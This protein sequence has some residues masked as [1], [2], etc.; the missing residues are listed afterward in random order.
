MKEPTCGTLATLAALALLAGGAN[1]VQACRICFPLPKKSIAD[2]LIE[3]ESVLLA[4]EDP[5]RPFHFRPTRLLKGAQPG[6]PLELFLDSGT[7][8]I[9]KAHP[10]RSILLVKSGKW[11]RLAMVD[12][13][14]RP[15]L[16]DILRSAP[17]W[18]DATRLD[19]FAKLF[20]HEHAVIRELA[21]LEVARAPYA[22]LRKIGRNVPRAKLRSALNDPRYMEWWALDILL[23]A[24]SEDARDKQ[25]IVDTVRSLARFDRPLHLGAWAT[26]YIEIEGEKAIQFFESQYFRRSRRVEELRE[27][28]LA[29]SVHGKL[30]RRDRI[31]A[32][33][34]VL[35]DRHPAL[36]SAVLDDLIAWKRTEMV[37]YMKA[38]GTKQARA[39]MPD[40]RFKLQRFL[41]SSRRGR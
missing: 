33:Y 15:V 34:R 1:P 29:L 24:Q 27:V 3:C 31:V 11:R 40:A 25:L 12:E 39:L 16:D 28:V 38:F 13:V 41:A 22:E 30:G 21:H 5:E 32:S 37:P 18:K 14:F 9:L 8:R 26:A 7:R 35:L 20:G 23:L 2:Y 19:H 4:R 36:A 10:D 17:T 6:K